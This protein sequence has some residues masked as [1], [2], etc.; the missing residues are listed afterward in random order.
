MSGTG[1]TRDSPLGRLRKRVLPILVEIV[2]NVLAP[3]VVYDHTVAQL[4]WGRWVP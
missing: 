2:I 3:L 4:S 1:T